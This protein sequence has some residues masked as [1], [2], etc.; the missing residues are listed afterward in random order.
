[1]TLDQIEHRADEI[2]ALFIRKLSLDDQFAEFRRANQ[3]IPQEMLDDYIR[4]TNTIRD[5]I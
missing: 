2:R 1:M 3:V 4:I 5:A